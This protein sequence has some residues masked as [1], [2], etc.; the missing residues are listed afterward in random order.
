MGEGDRAGLR[1]AY[2]CE[3]ELLCICGV[4]CAMLGEGD[5]PI[6]PK[7]M[8]GREGVLKPLGTLPLVPCAVMVTEGAR[9]C[10]P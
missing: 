10:S 5:A 6:E 7:L 4:V 1:P 2:G 8:F 9:V 3:R